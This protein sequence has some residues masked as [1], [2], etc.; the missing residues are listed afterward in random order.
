MNPVVVLPVVIAI[1]PITPA[2][3]VVPVEKTPDL[4]ALEEK[5][6]A[7]CKGT[8]ISATD[9]A[10]DIL[11]EM[12]LAFPIPADSSRDAIHRIEW[13]PAAPDN[14]KLHFVVGANWVQILIVP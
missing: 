7:F 12:H 10:Q 2:P 8:R 9:S 5:V 14:L 6:L 11:R 1:L 4:L 13:D 3:P